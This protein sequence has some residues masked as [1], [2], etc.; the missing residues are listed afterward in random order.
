M[1]RNA[2]PFVH[3][4]LGMTT[5]RTRCILRSLAVALSATGALAAQS[6]RHHGWIPADAELVAHFDLQAAKGTLIGERLLSRALGA[7]L[8]PIARFSE[9]VKE[10]ELEVGRDVASVTAYSTPPADA[11]PVLI[12]A[13]SQAATGLFEDLSDDDGY[14]TKSIDGRQVHSFRVDRC[15]AY[16]HSVPLPDNGFATLFCLDLDQLFKS[17]S[18]IEGSEPS[19]AG[20]SNPLAKVKPRQGRFAHIAVTR[21]KKMAAKHPASN[22]L[23]QAT[24]FRLE[25]GEVN[26]TVF[27][28]LALDGKT[29]ESCRNMVHLAQG[30][31]AL[32]R[33]IASN[34]DTPADIKNGR[35]LLLDS[36]AIESVG[37]EIHVELS[38]SAKKLAGALREK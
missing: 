30:L 31:I 9:W 32:A 23:K 19:L 33:L 22:L 20:S 2:M 38:C 15:R 3:E 4:H 11:E 25:A 28:Q 12:V 34:E 17:V 13:T 16:A 37:R 7:E 26:G 1:P 29:E 8:E 24:G 18:V 6:P 36:L 5:N 35:M 10:H 27:A 21:M 14:W